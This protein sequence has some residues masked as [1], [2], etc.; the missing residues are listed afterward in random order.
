MPRFSLL[1]GHELEV[2]W[3]RCRSAGRFRRYVLCDCRHLA[4]MGDGFATLTRPFAA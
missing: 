2:G 1:Y 3:R 4:L